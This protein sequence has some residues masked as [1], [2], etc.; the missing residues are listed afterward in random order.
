MCLTVTADKPLVELLEG[1][2]R[3]HERFRDSARRR[4]IIAIT[5]GRTT[6]N[7]L[8]FAGL[9]AMLRDASVSVFRV[10]VDPWL[11]REPKRTRPNPDPGRGWN[12]WRRSRAGPAFSW[13]GS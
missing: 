3:T 9:V 13:N 10:S 11:E 6:G 7:R 4:G 8:G 1:V 5:D 2:R 12:N